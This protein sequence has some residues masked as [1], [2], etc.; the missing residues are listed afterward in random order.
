MAKRSALSRAVSNFNRRISRAIEKN[1]AAAA[2]LPERQSARELRR[3][4]ETAAERQRVIKELNRFQAPQMQR[5]VQTEKG[6]AVTRWELNRVKRMNERANQARQRELAIRNA[7]PQNFIS[8]VGEVEKLRLKPRAVDLSRFPDTEKGREAWRAFA[9]AEQTIGSETWMKQK[10]EEYKKAY[11]ANIKRLGSAGR[12]LYN[13][14]KEIPA[15]KLY[16]AQWNDPLL[17]FDILASPKID[18]GELSDMVSAHWT[19]ELA[20]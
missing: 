3:G 13:Q 19:D 10:T 20:E 12:A 15:E 17:R 8:R 1:P 5:T 11:L 4:I 14:V 9:R 16:F 7:A 6:F 18:A 2:Y